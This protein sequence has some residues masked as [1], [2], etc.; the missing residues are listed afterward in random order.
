MTVVDG[1][2]EGRDT[3]CVADVEIST[4]NKQSRGWTVGGR[5]GEHSEQMVAGQVFSIRN[6][7]ATCS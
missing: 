7:K 3:V 6:G 5:G 1:G 2:R 4:F